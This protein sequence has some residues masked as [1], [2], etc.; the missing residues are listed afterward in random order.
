MA[1]MIYDEELSYTSLCDELKTL[2]DEHSHYGSQLKTLE[3]DIVEMIKE[4]KKRDVKLICFASTDSFC[5]SAM[6]SGGDYSCV[7]V[8]GSNYHVSKPCNSADKCPAQ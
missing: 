3:N 8:A 5:V 2:N 6:L 4:N 7:D 1:K